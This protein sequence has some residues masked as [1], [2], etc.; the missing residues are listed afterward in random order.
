MSTLQDLGVRS[1][2]FS[3]ENLLVRWGSVGGPWGVR[4]RKSNFDPVSLGSVPGPPPPLEERT[5]RHRR[6]TAACIG[7]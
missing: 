3:Q 6:R 2:R 1:P 5:A 4:H 7:S